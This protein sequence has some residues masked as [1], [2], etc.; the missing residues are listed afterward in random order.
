MLRSILQ[1]KKRPKND[2]TKTNKNAN[3][4]AKTLPVIPKR[5]LQTP[6]KTPIVAPVRLGKTVMIK[7]GHIATPTYVIKSKDNLE[8][9][10][11][12]IEK[13][14]AKK[15]KDKEKL[16]QQNKQ[17]I[18]D[19]QTQKAVQFK[20]PQSQE[21]KKRSASTKL[22][23][24]SKERGERSVSHKITPTTK[25]RTKKTEKN[26][27]KQSKTKDD[28]TIKPGTLQRILAAEDEL[29]SD[30][31]DIDIL[32]PNKSSKKKK[33][34]KSSK[35]KTKA[36]NT[37]TKARR[38]RSPSVDVQMEF[39]SDEDEEEDENENANVRES[40]GEDEDDDEEEG[41]NDNASF[42][43]SILDNPVGTHYFAPIVFVPIESTLPNDLANVSNKIDF[44][45]NTKFDPRNELPKTP[46]NR[47]ISNLNVAVKNTQGQWQVKGVDG[48][49]HFVQTLGLSTLQSK[50]KKPSLADNTFWK[51]I[52]IEQQLLLNLVPDQ[53]KQM[54]VNMW[55]IG[56][57]SYLTRKSSTF[58][59]GELTSRMGLETLDLV[60]K[61]VQDAES[62]DTTLFKLHQAINPNQTSELMNEQVVNEATIAAIQFSILNLQF[63]LCF[64]NIF[65]IGCFIFF[66]FLCFVFCL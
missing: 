17:R 36:K 10:R 20:L 13:I 33:K 18:A 52:T 38:G 39:E 31:D 3:E 57:A 14:K 66:G 30:V 56:D 35:K 15:R 45:C 2:K 44:D 7:H 32:T 37:K 11:K 47:I 60:G 55:S 4:N 8:E 23:Q 5:N 24:S 1:T 51:T 29:E 40:E 54:F 19:A 42:I 16:K 22:I 25:A 41:E 43:D 26:K 53:F 59:R 34:K 12:Q 65:V 46:N 21:S 9:N 63:C 58:N 62:E 50:S 6:L 49:A 48:D 27:Q 61:I 64:K 28:D